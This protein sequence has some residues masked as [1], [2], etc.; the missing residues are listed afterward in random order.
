MSRKRDPETDAMTDEWER[1]KRAGECFGCGRTE[2]VPRGEALCDF[3]AE[4][5][6]ILAADFIRYELEDFR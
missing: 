3:C 5:A 1:C 2:T 6:R 4:E